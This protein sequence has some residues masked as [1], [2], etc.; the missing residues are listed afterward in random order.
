MAEEKKESASLAKPAE[1]FIGLVDFFA[2]L[3]PGGIAT[4][5]CLLLAYKE[6]PDYPTLHSTVPLLLD[7]NWPAWV[8]FVVISYLLGHFIFLVGSV[9]LDNLYDLTYSEIKKN[10]SVEI[11][12][13]AGV[14]VRD[15]LGDPEGKQVDSIFQWARIFTRLRNPA[16]TLEVDR[17]EA[18]SKFFRSVTVLLFFLGYLVPANYCNQPLAR[19]AAIVVVLFVSAGAVLLGDWRKTDNRQIKIE[20]YKFYEAR[21]QVKTEDS[22]AAA[23]DDWQT[24]KEKVKSWEKTNKR[25]AWTIIVTAILSQLL[26]YFCFRMCDAPRFHLWLWLQPASSICLLLSGWRFMERRFKSVLLTYRL[27]LA[28]KPSAGA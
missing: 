26:F 18:D 11:K 4:A 24:A 15:S 5:S 9:T 20:A 3:L 19:V 23:L 27:L 14:N 10:D 8:G 12:N 21:K 25:C 28:S 22:E 17:L 16:T 1:F 13:N 6:H 2:I 7:K